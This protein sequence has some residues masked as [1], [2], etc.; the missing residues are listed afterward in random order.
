MKTKKPVLRINPETGEIK[1]YESISSTKNDGFNIS[2]VSNCCN[3]KNITYKKFF[4]K[5]LVLET[6][7]E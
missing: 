6:N 2:S 5:F 1:E 3:G 4:W 7:N